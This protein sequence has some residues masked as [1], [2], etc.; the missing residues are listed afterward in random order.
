M[1]G[2]PD[3]TLRHE[4]QNASTVS[5]AVQGRLSG[6]AKARLDTSQSTAPTKNVTEDVIHRDDSGKSELGIAWQSSFLKYVKGQGK[7]AFPRC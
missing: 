1:F 4:R 3:G 7:I 6:L 2:L 5:S